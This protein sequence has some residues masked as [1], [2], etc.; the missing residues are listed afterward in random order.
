MIPRAQK[1]AVLLVKL[2]GALDDSIDQ[3]GAAAERLERLTWVLVGL[4]FVIASL[5]GI[6]LYR[7]F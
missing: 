4:T 5:A 1:T 3:S 2:I 6:L 7:A